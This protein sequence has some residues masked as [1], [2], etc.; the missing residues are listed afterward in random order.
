MLRAERAKWLAE[1]ASVEGGN[2]PIITHRELGELVDDRDAYVA[3][4][5]KWVAANERHLTNNNEPFD[6]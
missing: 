4:L 3:R 2:D 1:I 5:K 6:A